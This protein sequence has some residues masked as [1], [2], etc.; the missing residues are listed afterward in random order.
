M[1]L[2]TLTAGA[3]RYA[4]DVARV[5]EVIPRVELRSVPHAPA[6][7]AGLLGYRGE[8]VPVLDLC[9][10][11]GVAASQDCLSTRIILVDDAS[12]DHNRQSRCDN[13]V[14]DEIGESSLKQKP[15]P[16][17]LGLVAEHVNDLA[18]VLP[19]QII[20]TP[21]ILPEV[22]YL[23][24]IVQTNQGIVQLIVV[25]QIQAAVLQSSYSGRVLVSDLN[26]GR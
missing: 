26:H 16:N 12:G 4:I 9:L 17:L 6:F 14:H 20:P 18:Y 21:L 25:E 10:L 24:A 13:I 2:L 3:N 7:V 23:G 8:I 19:E 22:P 5:V 15:G 1:L 11:L